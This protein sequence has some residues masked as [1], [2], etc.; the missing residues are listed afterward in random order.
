MSQKISISTWNVNSVNARLHNVVK[1]LEKDKPDI[2][3]LQEL[4]CL[5]E[6]FPKMEIEDLG[7]NLAI[8][9][10]KTYNGVAILSKFPI[11]ETDIIRGIPEFKDENSRYIEA[12]ISVEN[13]AIRVASVYV[14]NGQSVGS[15]KFEYKMRFFDA[16][17]NHMKNLS[18][19]DEKII[20][21]G[22]FNVAPEDI[23][24][25]D[26]KS[27]ANSVCFHPDEQAKYRQ[28]ENSG[29]GYTELWRANNPD[30]Q[31]FSW[32]DYRGGAYNYNKGLRID[33]LFANPL[34]CDNVLNCFIEQETRGWEKASDHAPVVCEIEV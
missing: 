10:Q 29:T 13:S 25:Y 7:Y 14:P 16:L 30:K 6:K 8:F 19:Y 26:P 12:S 4:K 17:Y 5:E 34:A 3:L 21:G 18:S 24:V 22:D 1:Y 11:D 32:W 15:E 28:L 20:I 27:L 33:F 23:D 31:A 2:V 9:G